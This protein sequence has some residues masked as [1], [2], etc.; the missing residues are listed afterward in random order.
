[1]T[2]DGKTQRLKWVLMVA[3]FLCP[4]C[5]RSWGKMLSPL[6][7]GLRD[8]ISDIQRY[9][10]MQEVHQD[11]VKLGCGVC[12]AGIDTINIEIPRD[13]KPLPLPDYT[14]FAGVV[15][16][17][18]NQQKNMVLFQMSAGTKPMDVTWEQIKKRI[19]PDRN[20]DFLIIIEDDSLWV[21]NRIGY[22]YGHR[23][24]D[25]LLVKNGRIQ[26]EVVASYGT[27]S[28]R[29]R[30]LRCDI[31][32][33]KKIV[34]NL[35]FNRDSTSSCM[36]YALK[37]ENQN[38][39][40]V[41]N[42]TIN[43]SVPGEL[44]G[45]MAIS[46]TNCTN[47]RMKDVAINGTYSQK[48]NYGYGICMNN[49]W[50]VTFDHLIGHG[51]WGVF[52]NNNVNKATLVNCDINR[53]DIHCYGKDVTFKNCIFRN[54][55]NQFSS[56][57][58]KVSF[59]KCEFVDFIPVLF[60][61]S[62][63][64][65]T[66]FDL[67]FSDCTWQMKQGQNYMIQAGNPSGAVNERLELKE[68]CWPNLAIDNMKVIAPHDVKELYLFGCRTKPRDDVKLGYI[69]NIRVRNMKVFNFDNPKLK[70]L[71]YMSD[72]PIVFKK[73]LTTNILVKRK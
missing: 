10:V 12:Y 44:Y 51:N 16:N 32:N 64:A 9:Y 19:L 54:L 2:D 28:S 30:F 43:T 27:R 57:Y 70:T 55:Y 26:N 33:R 38:D 22:K 11:A 69:H 6:A 46:V 23:R 13:V 58:G 14:D 15:L 39:V 53:F 47:V 61:S 67:S 8:C 36:T 41:E 4:N 62:Y 35:T 7:Y 18:R 71:L 29:P 34:K 37:I 56:V 21:K 60:E 52:G 49:V 48:R 72:I 63:N 59:E 24:K 73:R 20:S 50:N 65:Y 17:V 3:L 68:K 25:I 66:G 5:L 40:E 45:D 42:V 31:A 1:M